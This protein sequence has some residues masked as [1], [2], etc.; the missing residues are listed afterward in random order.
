ME[1]LDD[2]SKICEIFKIQWTRF[3]SR[4][5]LNKGTVKKDESLEKNIKK[6]FEVT[7]KS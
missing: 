7:T 4:L 3:T 5:S 1:Y 2:R 6:A